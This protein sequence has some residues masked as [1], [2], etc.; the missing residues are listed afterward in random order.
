MCICQ[1]RPPAGA[2]PQ[3]EGDSLS[4]GRLELSNDK[5]NDNYKD[6]Y[7]DIYKDKLETDLNKKE[8]AAGQP[9]KTFTKSDISI[10]SY[11]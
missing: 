9:A 2:R 4:A 6:N 7:K 11:L 1:V 5:D 10:I 3:Q 8:T